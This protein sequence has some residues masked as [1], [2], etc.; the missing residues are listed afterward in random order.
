[1]QVTYFCAIN[2]AITGLF[3]SRYCLRV[4]L[5]WLPQL[6][7]SAAE[8]STWTAGG[9]LVI[10][11]F[12]TVIWQPGLSLLSLFLSSSLSLLFSLS[13]PLMEI[14]VSVCVRT[15]ST[16]MSMDTEKKK[17]EKK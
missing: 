1:M 14:Q 16:C 5:A 12:K 9:D 7:W 13:G 17:V 3:L 4:Q 6:H 8:S 15:H 11:I 2:Q 10:R